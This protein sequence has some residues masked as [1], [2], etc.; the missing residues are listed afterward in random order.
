MKR[1][2]FN[3]EITRVKLNPEQAVLV[4]PCYNVS[5]EG[6]DV[7][8]HVS[9]NCLISPKSVGSHCKIGHGTVSS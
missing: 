6:T 2:K 8:S 7:A 4:C 1:P 3:P 9:N 5:E